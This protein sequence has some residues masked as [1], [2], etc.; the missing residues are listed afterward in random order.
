MALHRTDPGSLFF[1]SSTKVSLKNV[2]LGFSNFYTNG[3]MNVFDHALVKI[4]E[5]SNDSIA[6]GQFD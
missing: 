1:F 2:F 3:L 5:R 4:K 6:F